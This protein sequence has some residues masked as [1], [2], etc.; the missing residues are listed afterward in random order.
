MAYCLPTAFIVGW[1]FIT[2]TG[3]AYRFW[4]LRIATFFVGTHGNVYTYYC[5][6]RFMLIQLTVQRIKQEEKEETLP[7]VVL[8]VQPT[9]HCEARLVPFFNGFIY[10]AL[11]PR[12]FCVSSLL[13]CVVSNFIGPSR[14]VKFRPCEWKRLGPGGCRSYFSR[15]FLLFS[16][17][18]ADNRFDGV[19]CGCLLLF[20][21]P[22]FL[23]YHVCVVYQ[24]RILQS[25]CSIINIQSR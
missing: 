19:C 4:L 8:L 12:G 23:G 13:R 24:I 25:E 5:V 15:R 18:S 1:H 11:G 20:A 21:P 16:S 22:P 14:A 2:Y 6:H 3:L 17:V 9:V 10:S 7:A